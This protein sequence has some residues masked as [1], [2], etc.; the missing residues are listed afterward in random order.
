METNNQIGTNLIQQQWQNQSPLTPW[1]PL[2]HI[3]IEDSDFVL[4]DGRNDV[5][6]C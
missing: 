1:G 2:L 6:L 5:C 3:L 4:V